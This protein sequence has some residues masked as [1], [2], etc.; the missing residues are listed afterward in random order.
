MARKKKLSRYSEGLSISQLN[1][2]G[3]VVSSLQR[4]N[5]KAATGESADHGRVTKSCFGASRS[6]LASGPPSGR[7]LRTPVTELLIG[8]SEDG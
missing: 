6:V 8:D 1:D 3:C 7:S 5:H 2:D 4:A